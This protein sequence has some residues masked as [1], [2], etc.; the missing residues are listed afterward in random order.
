MF[1]VTGYHRSCDLIGYLLHHS[2]RVTI[3]VDQ[4]DMAISIHQLT[5]YCITITANGERSTTSATQVGVADSSTD[6]LPASSSSIQDMM[7]KALQLQVI[8]NGRSDASEPNTDHSVSHSEVS[9]FSF[10]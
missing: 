6:E 10:L 8:T 3:S 7:M 5:A 9:F 4:S 2:T 1:S